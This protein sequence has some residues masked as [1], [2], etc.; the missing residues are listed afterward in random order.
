LSGSKTVFLI[1][2]SLLFLE[3]PFSISFLSHSHYGFRTMLAT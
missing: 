1:N 3:S 2:L